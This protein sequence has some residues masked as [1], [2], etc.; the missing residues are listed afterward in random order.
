MSIPIISGLLLATPF[1]AVLLPLTMELIPLICKLGQIILAYKTG[2]IT[3]TTTH[4]FELDL[5]R[6]LRDVGRVIFEWVVNHLEPDH[7][8]L[9]PPLASFDNNLYKRRNH[10]PQR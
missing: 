7:P 1:A 5:Q 6:V 9:A 4:Q 2:L 3:P 8:D 10:S